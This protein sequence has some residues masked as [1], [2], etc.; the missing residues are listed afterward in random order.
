MET[1]ANSASFEGV[2]TVLFKMPNESWS[3]YWNRVRQS[4]NGRYGMRHHAEKKRDNIATY[5]W[6]EM[7]A[8]LQHAFS[9]AE[10][11]VEQRWNNRLTSHAALVAA[12]MVSIPELQDMVINA[13][14]AQRLGLDEIAQH[15]DES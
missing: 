2:D 12:F 6:R 7:S 3:D 9:A 1:S 10:P 8:A 13:E 14:L 4:L 5:Y 15:I 11:T